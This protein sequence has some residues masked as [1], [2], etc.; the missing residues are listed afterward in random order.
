MGAWRVYALGDRAVTV[1]FGD[2]VSEDAAR[3]V[4]S[5][6]RSLELQPLAGMEE[7]V[8]SYTTLTVYYDPERIR[9]S[10]AGALAG[11]VSDWVAKALGD[12]L[13]DGVDGEAE[14]LL[15][16]VEVP[17]CYEGAFAP[18]LDVVAGHTDL[19]ADKVIELHTSVT[20]RVYLIGFVPG[21]PYMGMTD[22][23]LEVPRRAEPRLRIAAGSV[24]LAG[25]QTGIYPIETPGGWQ[26]I[27]RTPLRLF[28]ARREPCCLLEA[29]MRVRFRR[30]GKD[31][32]ESLS[33]PWH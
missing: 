20:Y 15:P 23:R 4:A 17:V 12:R 16:P 25:R 21:F 29:G 19:T 10:E 28:D 3:F 27:G 32:F 31:E 33:E 9:R 18:D 26:V 7:M 6:R 2:V 24:G 8:P 1:S 11:T 22:P 30:I 14:A 5:L 13:S